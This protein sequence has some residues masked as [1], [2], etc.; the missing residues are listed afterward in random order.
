MDDANARR[1]LKENAHQPSAKL[2]PRPRSSNVRRAARGCDELMDDDGLLLSSAGH[3][4][5]PDGELSGPRF[6]C[7]H[8]AGGP[9]TLRKLLPPGHAELGLKR[10]G[11]QS[12]TSHT[13]SPL[14]C[15]AVSSSS[16][17]QAAALPQYGRVL[18]CSTANS[19][20]PGTALVSLS[21]HT[22]R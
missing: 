10:E 21:E 1:S 19:G 9:L 15:C 13:L 8:L 22:C 12:C 7:S 17:G 5:N 3:A 20:Q 18:N 4:W 6:S 16:S 14:T 2:V 11:L